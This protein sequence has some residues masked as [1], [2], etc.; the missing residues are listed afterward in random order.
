MKILQNIKLIIFSLLLALN[1]VVLYIYFNHN[2]QDNIWFVL[3]ILELGVV[4]VFVFII[5]RLINLLE[6]R[7]D[8]DD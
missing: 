8:Q 3:S 2:V 5:F 1:L 4:G 6:T 7:L